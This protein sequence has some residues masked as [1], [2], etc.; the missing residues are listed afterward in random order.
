[1]I[2][3][4]NG[5]GGAALNFKVVGGTTEPVSPSEN[6]IWVNTDADITSWIFS[7]TEPETPAEGMILVLT[8]TASTIEFNA[9]KKNGIQVYPMT[10]KQYV[11]GAWVDK[12]A[13]SYQ[14]GAWVEWI[15]YMY[16]KGNQFTALTGGW[17]AYGDV[18]DVK[19][20]SDH[21]LLELK[22]GYNEQTAAAH[23]VNKIDVTGISTL[24]FYIDERTS[25]DIEESSKISKYAAV[26]ISNSPDIRTD[27]WVAYT[28]VS[29]S[30]QGALYTVDISQ[31]SGSYYVCV[32]NAI[33]GSGYMKCSAVYGR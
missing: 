18:A 26:G 33:N 29:K 9:L 10:A 8:S 32:H 24:Y 17:A 12:T 5:G 25:D 7:A 22:S 4:M 23:T 11:S 14:D 20:E 15:T 1:M 6:T 30:S 28:Q 3:N 13:K 27:G 19:F 21:I 31:Y 16:D 2:F